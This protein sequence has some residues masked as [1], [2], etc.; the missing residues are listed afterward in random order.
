[1]GRTM[2]IFSINEMLR[3]QPVIRILRK[4]IPA[5]I[6]TVMAIG[7]LASAP[8]GLALTMTWTNGNDVWTSTTAWQTNVASGTDPVGLTNV[9][10]IAG[11]VTN[12]TSYCVGG[13][14][15]PPGTGDSA[16]FTNN[17]SYAVTIN[18]TT[19]VTTMTFSNQAGM[20]TL[21]GAGSTLTVTGRFR[22]ADGGATSTVLWAG[23]TLA[24]TNTVAATE[25]ATTE[26][27]ANTSNEMATLIV[28]NGTLVVQR[29]VSIGYLGSVGKFVISGPN[30]TVT[31]SI[32][33]QAAADYL[34]NPRSLGS[35]LIITNGGKLFWVGE[36]RATSN[37]VILVSDP[38]SYLYCTN[39]PSQTSTIEAGSVIGPG[40]TMIVSNGATIYSEGTISIGRNGSGYNTGIVVGAGSQ[41][42]SAPAGNLVVGV[43][44]TGGHSNALYVAN[45]GFINIQGPFLSV[46]GGT[47]TNS[48]FYMGGPGAMS[49]G[50]AVAVRGNS[51]GV[52]SLI[53]ISNAVFTCNN[54]SVVGSGQNVLN[55]LSKGT[56][57]LTAPVVGS[58]S[59]S[60]SV[61]AAAGTTVIN[62]GTINAV[63]SNKTVVVTVGTSTMTGNTLIIT[64]GGS[65]F[66]DFLRVQATNNLVFSD[67][68]LSSGGTH[69]DSGAN[70]SNECVIGGGIAAAYYDMT[71]NGDGYHSFGSPGLI[72]TNNA[73][74]R[75]SGTIAGTVEFN[76]TLVP[77][78]ANSIGS[79]FTSNSITFGSSAVLNYDL[80]TNSD[81]LKVNGNLDL[82]NSTLNVTAAGGFGAGTYVL[83]TYTN[84]TTAP[85]GTLTVG[86]MPVGYS[87]VVSD[88]VPNAQ[89]LLVVTATGGG[90]PYST[91]VSHYG[92]TGGNA[93]GTADPDADGMNNT[94]EF[95]AG[96]SPV[97]SAANL[98]IISIAR[99]SSTNLT[100]IYLGAS[101]DNS[102]NGG[103]GSRTNV[104]EG[105][106]GTANGS[107][108]N[109]FTTTGQTNVLSGGSGLGAVASFVVTNGVNGTNKYYRVRVLLP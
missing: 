101:G 33:M 104:L 42:I 9:T 60:M 102:Y 63:S 67:G 100:V 98:H 4:S 70:G 27:A 49:T 34:F 90:D 53:A 11:A 44:S 38:G 81:S 30:S 78:F 41:L 36:V 89:V 91:W 96:F 8:Q 22:V 47:C 43:G 51:Q 54:M 28:T 37:S 56:F 21:N 103:P 17:T 19:N 84:T 68:S 29:Q 59:N 72:V 75:G 65:L 106:T 14:G 108:S 2:R 93:L 80:G 7:L 61:G 95:L 23:G 76:G 64:N 6:A 82:G 1:M 52:D 15:G 40:N 77:G 73:F 107:Y 50:L 86:T 3:S 71:A 79:I 99:T 25:A 83:I 13:N 57:N 48:A 62:A 87:G 69:V 10:C 31:N 55:V 109:N 88:D 16:R 45:G 18:I 12:I 97:N 20:V 24:V 92:L 32:G 105:T 26:I 94:N 85:A 58:G 74:L 5:L 46:P 66:A 35:Q 39:I